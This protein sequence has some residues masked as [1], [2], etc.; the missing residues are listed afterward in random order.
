MD[1]NFIQHFIEQVRLAPRHFNLGVK[2]RSGL[3]FP[4]NERSRD[5]LRDRRPPFSFSNRHSLHTHT[6]PTN[7]F[8]SLREGS[9]RAVLLS[10]VG[11]LRK[12]S[13][14]GHCVACVR[15]EWIASPSHELGYRHGYLPNYAS[16]NPG[17]DSR[18]R[19]H[20][21]DCCACVKE[22]RHELDR[23]ISSQLPSGILCRR[24]VT[25]FY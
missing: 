15:P 24:T 9:R 11:R 7:R 18:P 20:D 19:G 14:F 8:F 12:C 3:G 21:R 1:Q 22:G 10:L 2:F 5:R 16:I 25:S 13:D 6:H 23:T 17:W 4:A